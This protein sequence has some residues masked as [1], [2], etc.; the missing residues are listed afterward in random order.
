MNLPCRNSSRPAPAGNSS[1]T[2]SRA[3][4]RWR[5]LACRRIGP[6]GRLAEAALPGKA[7][8]VIYLHM[9]GSPSPL[10]LFDNKPKNHGMERQAVPRVVHEGPAVRVHQGRAAQ[11]PGLPPQVSEARP[12]GQ[13]ISEILPH[14]A[15]VADDL[16]IV[17]LDED[18]PVQ[19]RPGPHSPAHRSPRLGRPSMGSCLSYGLGSPNKNLPAF[20]VMV[21]SPTRRTAGPRSGAAASCRRSTKACNSAAGAS[22]CLFLK[23]PRA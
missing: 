4:A 7:K 13:E 20:V 3:W 11:T 23:N 6:S 2:V 9:A 16:C 19:P 8:S 5:W 22:R 14:L 10:D 1:A 17:P 21:T 12:V 15:T 18:G